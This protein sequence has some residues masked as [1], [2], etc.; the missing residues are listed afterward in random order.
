M[1]PADAEGQRT[2]PPFFADADANRSDASYVVL[3]APYDATA[4]FRSG[5]AQGP[6]A[7]RQAAWNFETYNLRNGVDLRDV[8]I[9][10]AGNL[11][12]EDLPP[13]EMV[14]AV[15]EAVADVVADDLLPVLLGGEHSITPPSVEAVAEHHPDLAVLQLDAHLDYRDTYEESPWNHACAAR[16]VADTVGPERVHVLGVRSAEREELQEARRDGLSFTTAQEVEREGMGRVLHDVVDALGEGPLY[17]TLDIDALDPS[18]APGTGTPEP[19]GLAPRDV[20]QVIQRT[21]ARIVGFDLVEVSP[22]WDP[23]ITA[24]LAARLT[25]ELLAESWLHRE[26]DT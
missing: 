17:L 26:D 3:G 10:D 12:V 20:V 4:S 18:H 8:P 11:E 7:I 6:D 13:E 21:A 15:R 19:Y 14:A 2:F 9:H 22:P 1:P 24:P 23:G 16:R 5:T 25:R